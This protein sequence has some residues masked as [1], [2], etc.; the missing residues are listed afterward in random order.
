MLFVL[1]VDII[2]RKLL[3]H[4]CSAVYQC[5]CHGMLISRAI[6]R[7]I[8]SDSEN[9]GSARFLCTDSVQWEVWWV[10]QID[11]HKQSWIE[12]LAFWISLLLFYSIFWV[13]C[14][15]L[16]FLCFTCFSN[17]CHWHV[18]GLRSDK[19]VLYHGSLDFFCFFEMLN[20]GYIKDFVCF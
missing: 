9:R 18:S 19:I 6:G 12:Y 2:Y 5:Y 17:F 13:R 10:K 3:L 4:H 1:I 7:Y 8:T 14:I 20:G 16:L 11:N 15:S